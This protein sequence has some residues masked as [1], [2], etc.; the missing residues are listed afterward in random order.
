M[1]P[2]LLLRVWTSSVLLSREVGP[3]HFSVSSATDNALLAIHL[4]QRKV[5]SADAASGKSSKAAA[6]TELFMGPMVALT[7]SRGLSVMPAP[8]PFAGNSVAFAIH[9]HAGTILQEERRFLAGRHLRAAS[10]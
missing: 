7:G 3:P 10:P 2:T 8:L 4:P 1:S 9:F 6:R 5:S